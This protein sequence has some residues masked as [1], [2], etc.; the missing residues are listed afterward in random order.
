MNCKSGLCCE[1]LKHVKYSA[2]ISDNYRDIAKPKIAAIIAM[3]IEFII[4]LRNSYSTVWITIL[5]IAL[6]AM[7]SAFVDWF[8]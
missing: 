6:A 8:L 5:Y 2:N 4:H 7:F 1:K 3:V